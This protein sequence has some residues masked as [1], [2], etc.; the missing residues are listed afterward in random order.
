MGRG[1]R[2]SGY[3]SWSFLEPCRDF[4]P[5]KLAPQVGRVRSRVV[6]LD[7]VEEE[8]FQELM[9]KS[10][11]VSLHEHSFVLPEDPGEFVEYF[12][13]GRF[14]VGYEGLARSGLDGFFDGLLNGLAL[15]RSPD[16]WDWDNVVHQIGIYRADLDHQDLLFVATRAE[17]FLRAHREGRIAVVIHLEGPPRIGDDLTKVDVLYG[18]GVRCMG[19]TYSRGNEFGSGLADRVDRG[20]TD[21]GYALVERMN[22]LG[23]LIDISHAGDRTSLEVIEAS[24]DPVVVTHAGARALW[25]T[26]RMKPDEVILVLAEKGGV[27]GIEAAPHTTL[28]RRNPRHSI[29]SVM[30]HF[31]YVEKLVGIDHVAFGL[32]TLFGDHVALHRVF[33][34]YL[35]ISRPGEGPEHPVVEY[36]DGLENPSEFA[37]VV[38]WLIKHGYSDQEIGK[39]IGENVLRVAKRVWGG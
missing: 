4:K 23:I 20:L 26:R 16:P 35:S 38:R 29:E 15:I 39:V 34:A 12:R 10:V 25:P 9:E 27:F 1:K 8:R 22:K 24:R 6:E 36:V 13:S 11:V 30:E 33:S 19:V 7:K 37:N 5:F 3:T 17:D 21:L 18:L 2:Y 14:W 32:D 28:T 31:Q